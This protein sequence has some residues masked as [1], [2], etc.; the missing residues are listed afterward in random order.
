LQMPPA[1]IG[2]S[3]R[4]GRHAHLSSR[5]KGGVREGVQVVGKGETRRY[6]RVSMVERIGIEPMTSGLQSRRSPS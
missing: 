4:G 2:E 5:F 1:P 6:Q 3:T